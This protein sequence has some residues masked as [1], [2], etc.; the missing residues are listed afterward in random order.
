MVTLSFR[1]RT[2][3]VS[4]QVVLDKTPSV[5]TVVNKLN[6]IDNTFR[7][8]QM[9]LLAGTDNFITR[10]KENGYVF[11]LDFSKVY[12]NPRLG[13]SFICLLI[14]PSHYD[15]VKNIISQIIYHLMSLIFLYFIIC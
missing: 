3:F 15:R 10:A 12:W 9:E 1:Y 2:S 8:F 13:K 6:T 5:K 14:L 4:G 11:E 7:N